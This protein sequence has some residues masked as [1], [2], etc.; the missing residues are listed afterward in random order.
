MIIWVLFFIFLLFFFD[1]F[2]I[3]F[4]AKQS[5]RERGEK[6]EKLCS[7]NFFEG[8][9][10]WKGA[11]FVRW[12]PSP[13]PS[14]AP[15]PFLLLLVDVIKISFSGHRK[16]HT[17]EF[18]Y[19]PHTHTH[20]RT[21]WQLSSCCCLALYSIYSCTRRIRNVEFY[22]IASPPSVCLHCRWHL[23]CAAINRTI[24]INS[25]SRIYEEQEIETHNSTQSQS[26]V[27]FTSSQWNLYGL[28][29]INR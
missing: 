25:Y 2:F 26:L 4:Y 27:E 1:I 9:A 20:T 10:T 21:L 16:C 3:A 7:W 15:L 19:T 24:N 14:P 11:T 29:Y 12:A 5:E 6:D 8:A 22:L 17:M 23:R 28:L 18:R 13:L